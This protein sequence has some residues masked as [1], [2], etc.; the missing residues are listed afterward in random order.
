MDRSQGHHALQRRP[1]PELLLPRHRHA[2]RLRAP[3]RAKAR[4]A[5]QG[6]Q[7]PPARRATRVGR[8]QSPR[9][10][11]HALRAL[12][13]ARHARTRTET[14]H[15][16]PRPGSNTRRRRRRRKF[17]N[18]FGA[19]ERPQYRG[20]RPDPGRTR[21]YRRD[22][23]SRRVRDALFFALFF[24]NRGTRCRG[25]RRRRS[26]AR[27]AGLVG[28]E[29]RVR[30][31][32]RASRDDHDVHRWS[33]FASVRVR[34]GDS[35]RGGVLR[36]GVRRPRRRRGSHTRR[37]CERV[38]SARQGCERGRERGRER[39]RKLGGDRRRARRGGG[40]RHGD[41]GPSGVARRRRRAR[42]RPDA[43]TTRDKY[44]DASYDDDVGAVCTSV[45]TSSSV[46]A[47]IRR[48]IARLV[49]RRVRIVGET[50]TRGLVGGRRGWRIARA[51]GR[52]HA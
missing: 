31:D 11:T 48:E 28:D 43:R 29:G 3:H 45:C 8:R 44:D 52:W 15:R 27:R 39:R 47:Q 9:G 4:G 1:F 26:R 36:G 34:R 2:H 17:A 38:G 24:A 14:R 19:F 16:R 22:A 7:T 20:D 18:V 21:R 42:R 46:G 30:D 5:R 40:G 33:R 49:A 37:S 51:G 50:Q 32:A 25:T 12:R 35:R 6:G 23:N 41:A 13:A 10:E